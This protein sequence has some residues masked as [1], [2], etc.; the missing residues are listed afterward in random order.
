V[1]DDAL[2]FFNKIDILIN[3]AGIC[4]VG[5]VEQLAWSDWE[6]ML[7]INV[8]G[9]V[10]C[11]KAVL[12]NMKA[13]KYGKI[14]CLSSLAG[15]IGGIATG[16]NYAAS[17]AAVACITKSLAKYCA[18]YNINVNAVSPGF[19]ATDMTAEL[20]QDASAVPLGRKGTPEEVADAI[21]F[22]ASERSRYITGTTLDVNGG[23][24]MK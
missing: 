3:N 15:E 2:A 17:K 13:R 8:G 22:L 19:I 11:I 20:N 23:L 18:P 7:G 24:Y 9:N 21:L 10:K 16:P 4:Q 1:V 6:R 5:N 12:P 14:V